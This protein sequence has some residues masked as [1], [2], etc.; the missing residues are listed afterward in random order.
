M[1]ARRFVF[2]GLVA[3]LLGSVLRAAAAQEP[4]PAADT[5]GLGDLQDA[6]VGR[7]PR[8]RQLDLLASQS[9]LRLKAIRSE[10][11]PRFDATAY[12]QYQSEVISIPFD[13]PGGVEPFTPHK[14][15]YDAHL[16]V[17]QPL[18]D[19]TLGARRS[20]ESAQLAESQAGVRSTLF[21]LRQSVAE[22]YFAALLLQAQGAELEAGLTDLEA[23]LRVARDRVAAGDALPSE[24]AT[25]EAELLRR[26]QS[27]A[28][29]VANRGAAL[30]VLSDL[31]GRTVRERDALGLPDL[32]SEVADARA[33]LASVRERPEYV[34]FARTR[35]TLDQRGAEIARRNWP[36]ISAVGR[37]GVGRPGLNPLSDEFGSYWL[38]GVQLE[39]SPWDWGRSR[40]ER[41][42]LAIQQQ[43]VATE[44]A[45]F[46]ESLRRSAV[47]DLA[48]IDR[49]AE[50]LDADSAIITL[51]E[52]V[53]DE[54]RL[55]F[56]EGVVT[57]EDFVE[58]E[59]DLLAARLA[60]A[61]HRVEL[62]EARARFLTLVGIE[63]P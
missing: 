20:V 55:R 39:W 10:W 43:I 23:Q 53:L 5:L 37:A 61:T 2:L 59:T 29:V 17:R 30:A 16:G 22:S 56:S 38:A 14:D 45:A 19:P 3:M 51:R 57:S 13:L 41:Q 34:R 15:T 21:G 54:T 8:G 27:L 31:T 49:L 28:E 33:A 42:A 6:A 58:R 32:A 18:Y 47:R 4:A 9:E 50:T 35:E 52:R 25:L 26:R 1:M 63:V 40:L 11:L 44:E 24:T 46:T 60:R 36:R 7:D 12:A 48:A 62:A